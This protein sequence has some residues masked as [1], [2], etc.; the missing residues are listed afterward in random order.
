MDETIPRRI[1]EIC[2]SPLR[3]SNIYGVCSTTK[4]CRRIKTERTR[5]PNGRPPVNDAP[6][7][8]LDGEV[9]KP[10]PPPYRSLYL[11]SNR[12]RVW[13]HPQITSD[14]R[15]LRGRILKPWLHGV[16]ATPKLAVTLYD[17]R[18]GKWPVEV[19]VLV[20]RVFAGPCPEGMEIRHLDG[21]AYRNWW[22]ENLIYGSHR[23]N[24]IDTSIHGRAH[25][26]GRGS[27]HPRAKLTEDLVRSIRAEY[28][29]GGVSELQL[30]ARYGVS[31]ST[32]HRL[33]ARK[34]WTHVE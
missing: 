20:M 4:E 3:R 6:P 14:G 1:C 7:C 24:C 9:W 19:H 13:S 33:L 25:G 12:G 32:L 34:T 16:A 5:H 11:V 28:A 23:Q 26:P 15:R 29:A 30:A 8:D 10:A 21:D 17:R 31:G 18:G 2:G 22:P 27:V